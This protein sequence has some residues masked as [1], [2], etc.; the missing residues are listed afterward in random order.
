MRS[1]TG[2]HRPDLLQLIIGILCQ[3]CFNFQIFFFGY[4]NVFT[5]HVN[6]GFFYGAALP[7][8]AS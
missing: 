5:S 7:D 2:Q 8:P 1:R 3:S 6:V 4:V